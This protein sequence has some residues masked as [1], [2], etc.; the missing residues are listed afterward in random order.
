MAEGATKI[1]GQEIAL[2]TANTVGSA[3]VVRCFNNTA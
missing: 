2:T 3:S 1:I